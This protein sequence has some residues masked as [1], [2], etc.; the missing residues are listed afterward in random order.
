MTTEELLLLSKD[1]DITFSIKLYMLIALFILLVWSYYNSKL[2]DSDSYWE[3]FVKV[4][5]M[6]IPSYIFLFFSPLY[7]LFLAREVTL[8]TVV[9]MV[10]SIYTLYMTLILVLF[11]LFGTEMMLKFVGI[12]MG[13]WKKL[14][15]TAKKV[16]FN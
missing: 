4:F 10:G 3:I 1:I 2:E 15:I 16:R 14:K 6:K 13:N 9:T 11:L 7:T 8:S 5:F 12:D